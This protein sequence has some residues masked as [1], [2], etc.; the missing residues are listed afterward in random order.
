MIATNGGKNGRSIGV[1][2]N[3]T[4]A[5]RTKTFPIFQMTFFY[6]PPFRYNKKNSL[7]Q[8]ISLELTPPPIDKDQK[9]LMV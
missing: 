6:E 7:V 4:L 9:H 2:F 1:T 5:A 3:I 8:Y